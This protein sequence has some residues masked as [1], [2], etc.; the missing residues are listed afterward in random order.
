MSG[1]EKC[2]SEAIIVY[3]ADDFINTKILDKM[4]EKFLQGYEVVV[5]A[6]L[7]KEVPWKTAH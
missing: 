6:D 7:L 5:Q 1:F 4:Y 2:E 3:P